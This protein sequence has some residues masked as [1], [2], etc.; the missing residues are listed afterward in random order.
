VEI[1]PQLANQ[2]TQGLQAGESE[3]E[4]EQEHSKKNLQEGWALHVVLAGKFKIPSQYNPQDG[5][6]PTVIKNVKKI[7]TFF[8]TSSHRQT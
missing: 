6:A 5:T 8:D 7:P 3:R 1:S 2:G 4:N